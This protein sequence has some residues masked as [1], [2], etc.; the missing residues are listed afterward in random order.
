MNIAEHFRS[1]DLE[2]KAKK[3]RVRNFIENNHWLTDGEWKESVLR[4]MLSAHLPDSVKIGRGFVIT[5]NGPSTQC[6]ILLYRADVPV[7]FRDGD[8]AFVPPSSVIGIIEVKSSLDVTSYREAITKLA[9]I[10]SLLGT[11]RR[12]CFLGLFSYEWSGNQNADTLLEPL[13]R[14]CD[15]KSKLIELVCAGPSKFVRWW[16]SA[17]D[18]KMDYQQWHAYELHEMSAGYFIANVLQATNLSGVG[19]NE[20]LW[21]PENSKEIQLIGKE[22]HGVGC[23]WSNFS[24]LKPR[25]FSFPGRPAND[26]DTP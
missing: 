16:P 25:A 19:R 12:G 24:N 5:P 17:P 9:S 8:L 7:L 23:K 11:H 26:R 10:S 2:L 20:R 1:L 21:F 3:S 13:V 14:A 15:S 6:D 18:G 4:S 22:A